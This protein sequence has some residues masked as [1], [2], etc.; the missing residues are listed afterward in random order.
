MVFAIVLWIFPTHYTSGSDMKHIRLENHSLCVISL[1]FLLS[2]VTR[3]WPPDANQTQPE[4]ICCESSFVTTDLTWPAG[5]AVTV[6]G[7]SPPNPAPC[8]VIA[9]DSRVDIYL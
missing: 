9:S 1:L 4:N 5:G 3:G 2:P 6:T 8:P 7:E